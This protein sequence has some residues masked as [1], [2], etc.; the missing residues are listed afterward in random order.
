MKPWP[1]TLHV[2]SVGAAAVSEPR[3]ACGHIRESTGRQV[4]GLGVQ[5][6]EIERYVK[7]RGWTPVRH[8]V[9]AGKSGATFERPGFRKMLGDVRTGLAEVVVVARLDRVGRNLRGLLAFIEDDLRSLGVELV[10][11]AE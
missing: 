3:L 11:V 1:R 2:L 7:G 5:R 4:L 6:D 8:Y 9:D 10:S